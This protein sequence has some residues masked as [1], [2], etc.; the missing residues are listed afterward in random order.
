[1]KRTL[2]KVWPAHNRLI[3]FEMI[4]PKLINS[5]G[6]FREDKLFTSLYT[7]LLTGKIDAGL[8][9]LDERKIKIGFYEWSN[10]GPKHFEDEKAKFVPMME[11]AIRSGERPLLH[12][13]WSPV[14]PLTSKFV[15]AD[16][17]A[18]LAAYRKCGIRRVPCLVMAPK[19]NSIH[20]SAI[21]F[22]GVSGDENYRG[23]L[24]KTPKTFAAIVGGKTLTP[25]QSIDLMIERCQLVRGQVRAFHLECEERVHYH[26]TLHAAVRSHENTLMGIRILLEQGNA[27]SA[28]ALVRVAYEGFLNFYIDWLSPDFFGPRLHY[29]SITR[30]RN[31]QE[32]RLN[33]GKRMH[34]ARDAVGNLI[35]LIDKTSSKAEISPLGEYFYDIVYPALSLVSHHDYSEIQSETMD[36]PDVDVK[37]AADRARAIVS[38][39]DVITGELT[40]R[41]GDDVG[42]PANVA[43]PSV[44]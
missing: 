25:I 38:W 19:P 5:G 11:R 33:D 2:K 12:I 4:S 6:D 28:M 43:T 26:H 42:A 8:T 34:D 31:A 39:L 7:K 27:S 41:V 3:P 36:L 22:R 24:K 1:M 29:V 21:L 13:Y 17:Q 20:E 10:D 23:Y 37:H 35:D 15:C 18:T 9:R 16:D 32:K 44:F 40:T 14:N 30:V